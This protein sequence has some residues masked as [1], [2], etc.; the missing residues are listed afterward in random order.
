MC[1]SPVPFLLDEDDRPQYEEDY[2]D[3]Q[4]DA[5]VAELGNEFAA[6]GDAVGE[7]AG[8]DGAGDWDEGSQGEK[9]MEAVVLVGCDHFGT[10]LRQ[11]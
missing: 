8:E 1:G 11:R 5:N 2:K 9:M 4:E 7:T 6:T 3:E 10:L